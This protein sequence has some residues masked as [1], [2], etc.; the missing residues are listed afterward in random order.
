MTEVTQEFFQEEQ[1]LHC[2]FT[3]GSADEIKSVPKCI[4]KFIPQT[5]EEDAAIA[6]QQISI[7]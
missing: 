4:L 1:S 2:R 7:F 3:Q 6:Y 5:E